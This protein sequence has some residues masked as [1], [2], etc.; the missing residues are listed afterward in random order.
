MNGIYAV[1]FSAAGMM[2]TAL[3]AGIPLRGGVEIGLGIDL[4][5]N[6]IYGRGLVLAHDLESIL[7]GYPRILVGPELAQFLSRI[8]TG[9]GDSMGA[10]R[11]RFL[12]EQCVSLVHQDTDDLTAIDFLGRGMRNV[13]GFQPE[14]ATGY[15]FVI[16]QQEEAAS[17]GDLKLFARYGR[18]RR[19]YESRLQ[20][21]GLLAA[22]DRVDDTG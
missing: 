20:T 19:Y 13:E 14:V 5:E 1:L 2:A 12:A 6:E 18:L 4:S 9:T 15:R 16:E 21:W 3:A 17:H 7:A 8:A 22:S 10:Q 11:A